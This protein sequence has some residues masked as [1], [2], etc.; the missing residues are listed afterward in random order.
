MGR[1][2]L[3]LTFFFY[4]LAPFSLL[5]FGISSFFFLF[6]TLFGKGCFL[7]FSCFIALPL[8][9]CFSLFGRLAFC[10]R[11]SRLLLLVAEMV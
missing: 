10:L 7:T 6:L 1:F 11:F 3:L 4:T 9:F 5:V 8:P 2:I